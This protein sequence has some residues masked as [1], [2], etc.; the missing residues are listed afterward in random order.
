[1]FTGLIRELAD[2]SLSG[3]IL[4][5]R[6]EYKPKIGDSIAVN[7][8]CLT[9]TSLF[10]GGFYVQLSSESKSIL[11]LENLNGKVHIEPAM[12]L[13]ERLEGHIVQ[14]HID[15]LGTVLERVD[16]HSGSD[17]II[18]VPSLLMR[19]IIPKGSIAIDGVS[20]TVN[21]VFKESFRLTIIPHTLNST[22]LDSYK[23][24]RR[25]NIETDMLV[26]SIAHMLQ[27]GE[28]MHKL[29]WSNIDSLLMSY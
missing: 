1:M 16:S 26:R 23:K 17:F 5:L 11:A 7:G 4:T 29:S 15:G 21:E 22:L 28:A 6:A 2:A 20:L 10:S 14:G 24:G 25:I 18:S 9:V 8:A 12:S 13:G 27:R 3:D 19:Y